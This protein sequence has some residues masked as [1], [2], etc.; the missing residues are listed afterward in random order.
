MG[1]TVG[2][3]ISSP[4]QALALIFSFLKSG[5]F[6][7]MP[8]PFDKLRMNGHFMVRSVPWM[9][10]TTEQYIRVI[11]FPAIPAGMTIADVLRLL[12]Q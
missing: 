9:A 11:W 10:A 12:R 4:V 1:F 2:D 3:L 7:S 6:E 5:G 8:R